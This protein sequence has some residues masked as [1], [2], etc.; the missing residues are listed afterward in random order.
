MFCVATIDS[1]YVATYTSGPYISYTPLSTVKRN[2]AIVLLLVYE[3][4]VSIGVE[5]ND[6]TVDSSVPQAAS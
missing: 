6:A 2:A 4:V 3:K 5:T 1:S